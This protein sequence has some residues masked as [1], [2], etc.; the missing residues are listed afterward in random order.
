[1]AAATQTLSS[2]PCMNLTPTRTKPLLHSSLS[3]TAI[4]PLP[5]HLHLH[6]KKPTAIV[7]NA[8]VFPSLHICDSHNKS[9]SHVTDVNVFSVGQFGGRR[10]RFNWRSI[11]RY[12]CNGGEWEWWRW[13]DREQRWSADKVLT[14][15]VQEGLEAC[16][17]SLALSLASGY[18]ATAGEFSLPYLILM[19]TGLVLFEF[20]ARVANMLEHITM[21]DDKRI[22][23][24]I[25]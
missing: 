9:N 15:H 14:K 21:V 22:N 5:L 23:P 4:L 2:P 8:Q 1:M 24:F 19:V 10:T 20:L 17:E 25:M 6:Y 18:I 11:L 3:P 12:V 7:C 13:W 16:Q